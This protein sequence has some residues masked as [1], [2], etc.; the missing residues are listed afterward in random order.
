MRGTLDGGRGLRWSI[1]RAFAL[2]IVVR[3]HEMYEY[4]DID[5]SWWLGYGISRLR[6][7]IDRL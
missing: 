2:L 3:R 6:Y 7:P 5:E 4:D 1:E